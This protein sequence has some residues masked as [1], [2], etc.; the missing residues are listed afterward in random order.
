M[1]LS[2][3]TLSRLFKGAVHF[4]ISRG[5]LCPHR[6][7][8]AQIDYMSRDTFEPYWLGRALIA[9][10]MRIEIKTD[11]TE[12]S[13]EYK[14][15]EP[16]ERSNTIDLYVNGALSDVY[17]IKND[18]TGKVS[19]SVGEGEKRISIYMPC[20]SILKIKKF[21]LNGH[22]R[23][24]PDKKKRLL[25]IGDSITQG[26]GP[27]I[28]SE[29]YA[30]ILCREL[31]L[32]V[33]AQGIGGYRYEPQ[34]LM[35]IDGFEPDAVMVL[36]GTNYYEASVLE[37]HGYDY[38]KSANEFYNRLCELYPDKKIVCV[39]PL[40]RTREMDTERFSWCIDAIRSAC[41][42]HA[43]IT[44]LDGFSLMPNVSACLADGVHPSTFGS[45]MLGVSLAQ[46]LRKI[47]R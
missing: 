10:P 40:W 17:Y 39:T 30:N 42:P 20:E 11:A 16:H 27:D 3:L 45:H 28:S 12:I 18:L 34:D 1:T 37:K 41:A 9:G 22:Y 25:I 4:E 19:F 7:S 5:Y 35:H 13:F 26:A 14:A 32:E 23:A 38:A 31:D 21:T 33:L 47:L 43:Q 6:Y 15:S 36:L 2:P 24:V 46:R 44:V 29:A 8:R